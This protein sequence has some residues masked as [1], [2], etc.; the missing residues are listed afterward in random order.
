MSSI[1]VHGGHPITGEMK[2]QGSKNA[3][4]P[5]LAASILIHGITVIKHCPKITDVFCM[6]EILKQLG[7]QISW[8]ENSTLIIDSSSIEKVRL[9]LEEAGKMRSS[10]TLLGALLGRKREAFIPYPGGCSIGKRP[11]DIHLTVLK[12][13]G[14]EIEQTEKEVYAKKT[15]AP[16]GK[17]ML[18]FPS[19]GA[20]QNAVLA[21][22]YSD[23]QVILKNCA[24]EPEVTELCYFLNQAGAKIEGIGSKTL[25]IHGVSRLQE[26][27]Y[28][29][30]GDRIAAGTYL[31]AA[32]MTRG[33][34]TVKKID[35]KELSSVL[36]LYQKM[37]NF[38]KV[39]QDAIF[40]DA[41]KR[42]YL[43]A[44][45][46]TTEPYPG[47]PTDMQSQVMSLMTIANGK[48]E[49]IENV[50][51]D[52]FKT[53]AELNK[54]GAEITIEENPKRA[55]IQGVKQLSKAEV[56]APDLRGGAALVIAALQAEGETKIENAFYIERGYEDI[57]GTLRDLGGIVVLR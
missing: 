33:S 20:T 54:M 3:A 24:I 35:P 52:R 41:S 56:I 7:C 37:G 50:F 12:E 39:Y 16:S 22:I 34:L 36:E 15:K 27:T 25:I 30:R 45:N 29:I 6:I 14:I 1:I 11:I 26:V 10:I 18:S 5:I 32:V 48:S 40:L 46:V 31:A 47:F 23:S 42:K 13:L 2:I 43:E 55:L 44:L 57:A 4:L 28:E 21:S 8:E 19:V 49:I 38:V 9:P 51:E 53:A 17:V